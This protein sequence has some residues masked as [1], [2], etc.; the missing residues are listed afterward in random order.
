M[1]VLAKLKLTLSVSRNLVACP[2]KGS[3]G[4]RG[5]LETSIDFGTISNVHS[6]DYQ[7]ETLMGKSKIPAQL[8][9]NETQA[10]QIRNPN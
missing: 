5:S 9:V 7:Q 6:T 3:Q 4:R 2:T 1:L 8:P 10:N